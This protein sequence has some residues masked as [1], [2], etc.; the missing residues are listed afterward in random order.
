MV[1]EMLAVLISEHRGKSQPKNKGDKEVT[2]ELNW[3][4]Y[5]VSRRL[6]SQKRQGVFP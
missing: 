5:E 4:E 2:L 3:A 6:E 1:V